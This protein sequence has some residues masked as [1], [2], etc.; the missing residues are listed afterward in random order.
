MDNATHTSYCAEDRSYFS[1]LKKDINRK[2][3]E[4]GF[5]SKKLSEL[6]IIVAEMTSNLLKHADKGELLMCITGEAGQ[7]YLE[8][9]CIDSGPGISDPERM[10]LD[11]VSTTSTSGNGLGSIKRLSDYFEIYSIKGWGTILL[12]RIYKSPEDRVKP[13]KIDIRFLVV[14]KPGETVSGDGGMFIHTPDHFKLLVADGLGHGP[15]AHKAIV[16]AREAFKICKNDD[17]VD[18]IRFLHQSIKKTRGAVGTVVVY[19]FKRKIWK[20]AGVGNI[21]TGMM[22]YQSV[23][24]LMSYNGIIGHNIPNT[25]SSQEISSDDFHQITLCSDGLKTRWDSTKYPGIHKYDLS[26]L[27]A[28]LYKDYGRRTDDMSV[29]VCNVH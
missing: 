21:T 6:D 22:N 5:D 18:I 3:A 1:L 11:G 25:M 13:K 26:F 20:I 2:A 24:N 7:E 19:D 16:E 9:I 10:K 8:L 14:A 15:E 27:A 28:A 4:A 23:R 17:P 29:V 12:C